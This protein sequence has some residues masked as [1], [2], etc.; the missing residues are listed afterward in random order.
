[1]FL[2]KRAKLIKKCFRLI[3]VATQLRLTFSGNATY[4]R[5]LKFVSGRLLVPEMCI[6]IVRAPEALRAR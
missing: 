2:L 1:M 3:P 6:S 4:L 5:P